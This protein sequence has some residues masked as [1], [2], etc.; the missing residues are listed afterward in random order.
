MYYSLTLK[1]S[2]APAPSLPHILKI[3]QMASMHW[4]HQHFDLL[5]FLASSPQQSISGRVIKPKSNWVGSWLVRR[6]IVVQCSMYLRLDWQF[7]GEVYPPKINL[8][9]FDKNRGP[10]RSLGGLSSQSLND[11]CPNDR[12]YRKIPKI[13]PEAY[14]FLE[15]LIYRGKLAFQNWLGKP[16]S[17]N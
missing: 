8:L 11:F 9:K 13:N 5:G 14:I 4:P 2:T 10:V 16:Y 3:A 17:W 1:I 7:A 15:G 12:T 6:Q